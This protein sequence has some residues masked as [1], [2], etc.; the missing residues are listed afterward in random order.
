MLSVKGDDRLKATVL[1]VK[2]ADTVTRRAINQ[3]TVRVIGPVW[4]QEVN[5]RAG[6]RP[7]DQAVLAKG[8]RVKGGNPPTAVAATSTRKLTGGLIPASGYGPVEFGADD[9]DKFVTYRR[10]STKGRS[11]QVR[12]RTRHQLPR[13]VPRGRVVYPAFA[14]VAPRVVSLWVQTVVRGYWQAFDGRRP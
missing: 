2:A 1:L 14:E 13:R 5:L 4:V 7:L 12:R 6:A 9:R 3:D 10:T 11:H 8:A